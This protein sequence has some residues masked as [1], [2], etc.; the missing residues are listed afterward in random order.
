VSNQLR[1]AFSN[2]AWDPPADAAVAA[3]LS[4]AGFTGVE[5]APTTRWPDPTKATPDEILASP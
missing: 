3:V 5:I 1:L 2:I 4:D